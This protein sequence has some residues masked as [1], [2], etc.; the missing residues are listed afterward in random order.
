[1][2]R[3]SSETKSACKAKDNE[4]AE[5]SRRRT[6]QLAGV[7]KAI[8]ILTSDETATTFGGATCLLLRLE[9]AAVKSDDKH[10]AFQ[11]VKGPSHKH[12]SLRKAAA[13]HRNAHSR[14]QNLALEGF[15]R[16]RTAPVAAPPAEKAAAAGEGAAEG[17]AAA[18]VLEQV[19]RS[20]PKEELPSISDHG[21]EDF[22]EPEPG[23]ARKAKGHA[24][25]IDKERRDK[26]I[27]QYALKQ[28][29]VREGKAAH[30]DIRALYDAEENAS[31]RTIYPPASAR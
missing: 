12:H 13:S 26:V 25:G 5:R 9:K 10:A 6:E 23:S 15:L 31:P 21:P 30:P 14:Q 4:W 11:V 7:N 1:M 16:P 22:G 20:F 8:E 29:T 2:T 27:A 19:K 3:S 17:A 18:P 28:R 24:G